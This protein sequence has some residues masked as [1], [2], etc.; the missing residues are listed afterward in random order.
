MRIN[1]TFCREVLD[2]NDK[3]VIDELNSLYH[4]DCYSEIDLGEKMI[5][6]KDFGEFKNILEKYDF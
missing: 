5:E 6:W 4:A 3:V 1:C 2:I